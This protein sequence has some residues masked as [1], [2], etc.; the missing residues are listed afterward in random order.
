MKKRSASTPPRAPVVR[1]PL[2][3]RLTGWAFV[4]P[5]AVPFLLAVVAPIVYTAGLSV[6]QERLVGGVTFVG[7]DNYRDQLSDPRFWDAVARVGIFL[8]IQV[9]L[10]MGFALGAALA[11]DSARLYAPSVFR[12]GIFLPYAVPGVVASLLWGYIYGAQFGLVGDL[13]EIFDIALPDPLSSTLILPSIG[14]IGLWLYVG[15]NMLVFYAA[16]QAIPSELFEAARLDGAGTW[17]IITGIKLPAIRPTLVVAT[18][19]SVIGGFQLFNE[20]NILRSMVPNVIST[21]FT[22]NMYAYTLS[23]AGQQYNSA[24]TVAMIMGVVTAIVA[25]VVQRRGMGRAV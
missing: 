22:P 13:K 23:F 10:M 19:F 24:A 17:H 18:V 21:D 7:L 12:L 8:L 25:F 1:R 14:N 3:R 16:L 6:F 20:P 2:K 15:Y 5:F 11:L 4:L 9:P